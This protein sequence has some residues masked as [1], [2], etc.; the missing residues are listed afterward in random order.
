MIN[1]MGLWDKENEDKRVK[2]C[3]KQ[4]I[5]LPVCL[6]S[7]WYDREG[8]PCRTHKFDLTNYRKTQG[9]HFTRT[10]WVN[11]RTTIAV[12]RLYSR[13]I[14]GACLLSPQGYQEP[15]WDPGLGLDLAQ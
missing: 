14:C 9:N 5:F 2:N 8:G 1:I 13:I 3:H 7:G 12:M 11:V 6:P 4:R 10:C 15:D